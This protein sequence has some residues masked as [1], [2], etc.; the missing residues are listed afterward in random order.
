MAWGGKRAAGVTAIVCVGLLGGCAASSSGDQPPPKPTAAQVRQLVV[1]TRA[2]VYWFGPRLGRYELSEI[3][4]RRTAGVG[5][6]YGPFTCD[7]GSGCSAPAGVATQRRNMARLGLENGDLADGGDPAH[8]WRTLGHAVFLLDGC[9]PKGFPEE[10]E[11]LTGTRSIFL[12]SIEDNRETPAYRVARHL[13][14]LNAHAPWPLPAP[15]PLSCR[16]RVAVPS[17]YRAHMPASLNPR[18]PC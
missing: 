14:P 18:K 5:F 6:S 2:P 4:K 10:A 17:R 16:E 9:D 8:C 12:T 3:W 1:E 7:T 11:V 15:D 13:K